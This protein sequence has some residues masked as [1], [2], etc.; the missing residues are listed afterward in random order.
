MY[1]LRPFVKKVVELR[2][3]AKAE[4]DEAKG[5]SAKLIGNSGYGK[6]LENVLK[7]KQHY[8]TT[9]EDQ[10]MK[11][12]SSPFFKNHT[13]LFVEDEDVNVYEITKTKK[14]IIDS[15]PVHVG[16]SILQ[17]AKLLFMQFM[18]FLHT[19]LKPN[20]FRNIY[21]DTDSITIATTRSL[22][23]TNTT[24]VEQYRCIFDPIVKPEMKSS[25]ETNMSKWFVLT[26]EIQTCI[27][28]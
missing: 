15:K 17:E 19:H 27:C 11:H 4:K 5:L 18:F 20:S 10:L 13:D 14:K 25:W 24:L 26:E 7:H 6:T 23:P 2:S 1:A 3:E 8:I 16:S 28:S 21:T 12:L 22:I 9:D